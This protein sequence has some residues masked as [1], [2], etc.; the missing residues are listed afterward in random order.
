MD[1]SMKNA[2][3]SSN[4]T[5]NSS[6]DSVASEVS[7]RADNIH[8]IE[9]NDVQNN[10]NDSTKVSVERSFEDIIAGGAGKKP[11]KYYLLDLVDNNRPESRGSTKYEFFQNLVFTIIHIFE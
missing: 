4:E 6:H 3:S 7:L 8:D 1:E 10:L 2:Y 5:L 11:K 9:E